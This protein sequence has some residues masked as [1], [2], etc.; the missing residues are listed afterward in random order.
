[1]RQQTVTQYQ[2][3][4]R[5]NE[6]R[7]TWPK[8]ESPLLLNSSAELRLYQE[9]RVETQQDQRADRG[10]VDMDVLDDHHRHA[11]LQRRSRGSG[12]SGSRP[13]THAHFVRSKALAMATRRV[14]IA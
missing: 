11:H 5:K 2:F 13:P 9:A 3:C 6:A 14:V 1:M 4:V 12:S 7:L 10:D 8:R